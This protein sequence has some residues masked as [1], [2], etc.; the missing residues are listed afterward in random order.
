MP[1]T[2]TMPKLSP[3]MEKGVLTKWHKKVGDPIRFGDLLFEVATDKATVEHTA[4][5]EG[6]LRKILLEEGKE[7][8]V[9][10]AIAILTEGKDESIE[11]YQ[12]E[13]AV[14]PPQVHEKGP[15]LA[16]PPPTPP[17]E[18]N[19]TGG[20]LQPSFVPEPPLENYA[21]RMATGTPSAHLTASPLARKL[22]RE[23]GVDLTTVK[24]SGPHQRIVSRDLDLAQPD[25]VV[26]F[27]R[28]EEPTIAPGSFEEEPLTPMRKRIGQRLQES[29][30]FIPH[31]YIT[32][33]VN[34]EAMV[35]VREQLKEMGLSI[36]FNDLIVRATALALRQHPEINS[37]F[38]SVT[39][40]IIRY[41]TVDISIAVNLPNGLITPIVRHADYKN[42]G[43]LSLEIK[44]LAKRARAGKLNREE[45]V[46]GSFTIS[47][48]GMH[49]IT[50]FISVINPPQAAILAVASIEERPVIKGG[51]VSPGKTLRL[52]LS[53]DHRVIN[54][55]EAAL[56]LKEVE[57]LLEHAASLLL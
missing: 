22:A 53:A 16:P 2:L 4:L 15:D 14:P 25:R 52:T 20:L 42:L 55:T 38:N 23:K 50:E 49:G 26:T 30:T 45:Y 36:S 19:A 24:G 12:P 8:L 6:Y 1:S 57:R 37:G 46:G 27:G 34:A 48:L 35:S 44:E 21:F 51:H 41:K 10:Q 17:L 47:N 29:K 11:G 54:G 39:T 56:F 43:E 5:E 40:S 3:T 28:R 9:N 18:K 31:F 33:E 32:Q 7:A 13:G